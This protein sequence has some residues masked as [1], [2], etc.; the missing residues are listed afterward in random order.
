[1]P[2]ITAELHIIKRY[3]RGVYDLQKAFDM[4]SENG[5]KV[6]QMLFNK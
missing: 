3:D 5:C 2:T 1:M 4:G 6:L